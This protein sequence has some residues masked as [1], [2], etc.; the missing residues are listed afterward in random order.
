MRARRSIVVAGAQ[1]AGKTTLVR[2]LC[3]EIDALE[4]IGTFETE[5]ELHLH[6]LGRHKVVHAWEARPGSGERGADGRQA[7]EFT[8]DEALV[9]SFRFNLSRQIVGE[10]RGKEIWAM[11]KAME[12]GTGSISTTHA[13]DAVA[14]VRKLVTCAMEAGPHVTQGLATSK[15]AATVDLIVQLSM[16][17][18]AAPGGCA[19]A[20]GGSPRSSPSRPAR[21]RP[22]TRPRTCSAPTPAASQFPTSFPT[23]TARSPSTASTWRRTSRRQPLGAAAMTPLLPSLA[24]GLIA[25]RAPRHRRRPATDSRADREKPPGRSRR[26]EDP[27]RAHPDSCFLPASGSASS[28]GVITGLGPRAGHRAGRR[29]RAA[30]PA[31]RPPGRDAD[32]AARSHGGMDSLALRRPHRRDRPRAGAGRNAAL[33][34]RADQR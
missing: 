22:A 16:E 28:A 33:D 12:S 3:A 15:L 20:P 26:V 23:N 27:D 31:V 17:T 13:A 8:L 1:G 5:Y 6:E 2:A 7:G 34:T 18:K 24:G 21:R 9:D 32:R 14:A 11:I 30:D 25:A 19:A 10:V 29:H 4:A